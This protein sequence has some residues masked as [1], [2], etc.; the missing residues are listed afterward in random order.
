MH[1]KATYVRVSSP[2]DGVEVGDG[3]DDGHEHHP[4]GHDAEQEVLQR[5]R[6]RRLA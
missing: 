2:L 5:R 1:T 4:A 3:A 6:R